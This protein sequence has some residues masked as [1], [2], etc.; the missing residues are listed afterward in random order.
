[1][2]CPGH[3]GMANFP[4]PPPLPQVTPRMPGGP[5]SR[6]KPFAL[7]CAAS[8]LGGGTWFGSAAGASGAP[9]ADTPSIPFGSHSFAYAEG[10]LTPTGDQAPLDRS[11]FDF[12]K[13]WKAN[14]IK[15]NCGNSWYEV[16]AADADHP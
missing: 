6:R 16:Y 9:A 12:Y 5:M 2:S 1:M 8:L 10:T 7:L 11:V 3:D 15:Q 14:F 4:L 13:K